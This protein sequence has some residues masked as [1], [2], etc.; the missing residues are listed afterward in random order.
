MPGEPIKSRSFWE[1]GFEYRE[2]VRFSFGTAYEELRRCGWRPALIHAGKL[3]YN[4]TA[5]VM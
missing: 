3:I 4:D 1:S 5:K 2:Q